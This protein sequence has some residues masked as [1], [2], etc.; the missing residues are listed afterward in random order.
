LAYT[1]GYEH[2]AVSKNTRQQQAA[3]EFSAE[4]PSHPQFS[5]RLLIA[6]TAL[7]RGS[8]T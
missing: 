1:V 4:I 3:R 7:S 5:F 6:T 8:I 2:S